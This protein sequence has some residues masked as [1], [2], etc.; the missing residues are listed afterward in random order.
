MCGLV[1]D[2]WDPK[3]DPF[4]KHQSMNPD[5]PIV[6]LNNGKQWMKDTLAGKV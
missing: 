4:S 5:C 1:A 3:Q 2:R 6:I